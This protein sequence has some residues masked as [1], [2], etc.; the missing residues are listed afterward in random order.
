MWHGAGWLGLQEGGAFHVVSGEVDEF[1]LSGC[2]CGNKEDKSS[3]S[4]HCESEVKLPSKS[5]SPYLVGNTGRWRRPDLQLGWVL[6][7]HSWES[8]GC[9]RQNKPWNIQEWADNSFDRPLHSCYWTIEHRRSIDYLSWHCCL[10]WS[11]EH[12]IHDSLVL[13]EGRFVADIGLN[14]IQTLRDV[15]RLLYSMFHL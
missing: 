10:K 13:V 4:D 6:L 8:S 15:T 11:T 1:G 12:S 9:H 2:D 14:E 7:R 5:W 3:E